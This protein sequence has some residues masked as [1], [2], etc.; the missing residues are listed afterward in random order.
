M[1][2]V[3]VLICKQVDTL[4]AKRV[5][6]YKKDHVYNVIK[7]TKKVKGRLLYYYPTD[8]DSEDGWIGWHNDSGFLTGL[9]SAMYFNDNTGEKMDNPDPTGGLWAVDRSSSSVKVIIPPDHMAVQCGECLQIVTGGLLVA[10][11]HAVRSSKSPVGTKVG[12]AA[13]PVFV[14]TDAEFLL[15]APEGISREQVLDKTSHSK[16]PPL[17]NRWKGGDQKF[18]DF[19]GDTFRQYYEWNVS[20]S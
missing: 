16:V 12:R 17:E 19:L 7:Q 3:I 14:D 10:T 13:F 6:E 8:E 4:V 11:P 18:V 5:P 1:F 9:C 2:D 20:D 15:K